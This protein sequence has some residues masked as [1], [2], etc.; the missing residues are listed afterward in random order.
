MILQFPAQH[1]R[2]QIG[3][4]DRVMDTAVQAETADR[5]VHMSAI[6]SEKQRPLRKL[7]ATVDERCRYSCG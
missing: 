2:K 4:T 5:I 3:K 7:A 6:A 1:S